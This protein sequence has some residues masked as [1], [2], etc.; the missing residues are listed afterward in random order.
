VVSNFS[1]NSGECFLSREVGLF[2]TRSLAALFGRKNAVDLLLVERLPIIIV[3]KF[4]G[5]PLLPKHLEAI[6][7][8][9]VSQRP[10][11]GI[12]VGVR[13][14]ENICKTCAEVRPINIQVLL[15]WNVHFLALGAV[16][17]H[18]AS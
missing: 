16:R 17:L 9:H 3:H 11:L 1:L 4:V 5:R 13:L 14:Q 18:S 6:N 12:Q 7:G 2:K 8:W 15:T 10:I